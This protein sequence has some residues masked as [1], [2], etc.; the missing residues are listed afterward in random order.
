MAYGGDEFVFEAVKGIALADVAEAENRPGEPALV[1]DGS[2]EVLGRER[3]TVDAED[4]ILSGRGQMQ[5]GGAPQSAV[6]GA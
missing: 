3:R 5:A 6:F 2:E 4:G 1:Q